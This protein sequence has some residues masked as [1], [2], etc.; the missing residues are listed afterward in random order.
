M[1]LEVAHGLAIG[2]RLYQY[3]PG[4]TDAEPC[5][6]HAAAGQL[7]ALLDLQPERTRIARRRRVEIA[8]QEVEVMNAGG[9]SQ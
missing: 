4:L 7:V 8:H 6:T 2:S 3:D 1:R 9:W 5:R